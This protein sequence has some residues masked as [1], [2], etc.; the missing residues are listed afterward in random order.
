VECLDIDCLIADEML[1]FSCLLVA[2]RIYIHLPFGCGG[3]FT[4]IFSLLLSYL[5]LLCSSQ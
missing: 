5:L 1:K 3:E 4:F 2:E